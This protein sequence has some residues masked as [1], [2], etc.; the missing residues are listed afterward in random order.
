[1]VGEAGVI[2][3]IPPIMNH[4]S[5]WRARLAGNAAFAARDGIT[6]LRKRVETWRAGRSPAPAADGGEA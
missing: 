4:A 2:A 6:A 5:H 3:P 1:M